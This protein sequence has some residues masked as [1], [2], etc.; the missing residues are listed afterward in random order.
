M[1]QGFTAK[2]S[3]KETGLI[4]QLQSVIFY[5]GKYGSGVNKISEILQLFYYDEHII[6]QYFFFVVLK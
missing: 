3:N 6:N 4:D 1:L 2:S 5:F